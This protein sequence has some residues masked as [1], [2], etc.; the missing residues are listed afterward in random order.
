MRSVAVQGSTGSIGTSTLDVI[1]S[2]PGRFRVHSLVAGENVELL[3]EQVRTFSPAIVSV[4]GREEGVALKELLPGEPT[5]VVWGAE[6]IMEATL[7]KEVDTVVAGSS[8]V[9]CLRSV[10]EA[11]KEG[12]RLAIANKELL[13]A[14]GDTIMREA[15]KA[16]AEVIPVDSEHSAIFQVLSG[17]R[18]EQVRR[19]ILTASG[20]PFYFNEERDLSEVTKEE[21]LRHPVW[22]MGKKISIDSATMMNKGFEIIEAMH[23]FQ[24]EPD[25]IDVVIH[26]QSIVHSM[27]EFIDGSIIAQM[28]VPDMK[29]PIAFALAYPE[30]LSPASSLDL[31]GLAGELTFHPP[32]YERFPAL[33]L[34][35]KVARSGGLL[36]SVLISA[37]ELAVESFMKGRL[38]FPQI[39]EVTSRAVELF[40][41]EEGPGGGDRVGMILETIRKTRYLTDTI[42]GEIGKGA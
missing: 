11:V 25:R 30:R 21:A 16:S 31:G 17:Q 10:V 24:L 42:I 35:R 34:A 12:K 13:V 7:A 6:G 36:P 40:E 8:G 19:V 29:V 9:Y 27:V 20:G 28:G 14:A 23:L 4:K 15:E 33:L 38:R 37:N 5:R 39:H 3:A 1:G 18:K 2:H 26:P 41:D 32:D 22:D